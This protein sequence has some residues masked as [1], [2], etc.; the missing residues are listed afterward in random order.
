MKKLLFLSVMLLMVVCC[1]QPSQYVQ[2]SGYAQGSNYSVK[3]N[4]KGIK[5]PVETIRDSIDAL[6]VKIDTTLSGYNKKSLLSR[7]NAGEKIPSNA[8]FMDVYRLGYRLWERSGGALDFGA[9]AL[10]DAWGFGFRN[11]SFPTDEE[12]QKLLQKSG[13]GHLPAELPVVDGYIDPA[14]IGYPRL[15]FNAIAQGY[16]C[17][18]IAGYLYSLGA[19]DMLV[20]IGEIWCDGVNPSGEPWSVGI[21]RPVD[22]PSDGRALPEGLDGI[23]TSDGKPA[24]IV[25]S[26]N[27]RKFYIRDGRK[28][29]HTINPRT[30]YPVQHNLLSATVVSSNNAA[31]SDAIATWCMVV[32]LQGA[33]ILI[34]GDP[35]LEGYLIYTDSNGEMKEWASPGFTL[36]R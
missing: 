21:D 23:W 36:R 9:A 13:M 22:Q 28:Y 27:Y 12:I 29:S 15:N 19:K 35:A 10:Y 25:T 26:G 7:F 5:V 14:S 11:S 30:G 16:S 8:M 1:S 4:M 31:E 18:V 17:D 33:Q 24:G 2:I 34:L 32:G 3:L 20:D 6:I